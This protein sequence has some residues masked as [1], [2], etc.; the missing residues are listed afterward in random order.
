MIESYIDDNFVETHYK[1]FDDQLGKQFN[2][3]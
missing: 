1:N 3:R 2:V